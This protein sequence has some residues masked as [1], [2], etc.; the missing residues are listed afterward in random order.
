MNGCT[1]DVHLMYVLPCVGEMGLH[2]VLPCCVVV[3]CRDVSQEATLLMMAQ[4]KVSLWI[5]VQ[6][7]MARMGLG[8]GRGAMQE[9]CRA[10]FHR[11]AQESF[12]VKVKVLKKKNMLIVYGGNIYMLCACV[13]LF[14]SI[15][16][17]CRLYMGK[18]HGWLVNLKKGF[19]SF[20]ICTVR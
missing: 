15:L 19:E 18:H 16:Y 17:V 10:M 5:H 9:R 20:D 13:F 7:G 6:V 1:Y 2:E 3:M 11:C 12:V 8:E 14:R 4:F